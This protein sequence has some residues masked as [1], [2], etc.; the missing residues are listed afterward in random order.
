MAQTW[1][2]VRPG[3]IRNNC[4]GCHAHSQMPTDFAQTEA[5]KPSYVIR[6]LAHDTPLLS[7]DQN[8]D[9]IVNENPGIRAVDVEY[10]RDIRPVLRR[11]CVPCHSKQN[12]NPDAKLVLDDDAIDPDDGLPGTYRRLADDQDAK[13]GIKP[14]ISNGTWRQSNASRYIRMFQS[15]RSLLVWKV[16]GRRLDGWTNGAHPT[17][18]T[19]GDPN[20]LPNNADANLADL[21]YTG[22][23]MPPSNS[24]VPP[25]SADEKRNFARWVD[26]GCPVDMT[27][28]GPVNW[29]WFVDDLRPTLTISS[30]RAGLLRQ[31]VSQLRIGLYDY[32]SGEDLNSLSV[33]ADFTVDGHPA[34]TELK[35][36]LQPVAG[37][38]AQG[39]YAMPLNQP[40]QYLAAG[41]LTVSV[42]DRRGNETRMERSFSVLAQ[43]APVG[44]PDLA[45]VL[46]PVALALGY[47]ARRPRARRRV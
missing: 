35:S 39:I 6:D 20:S 38:K 46:V 23:I 29:G 44:A 37:A 21:D 40:I 11:S 28:P 32:Y 41:K 47:A 31:A 34:G 26:L 12:V 1:H 24:G 25:L 19:P 36:Y 45:W 16:F 2:Q 9:P 30:P 5:A 13:Y 43:G 27:E 14:V 10:K 17:E 33:K 22:N 15:R 42:L 3:E 8:G 7:A 4:G 18:A